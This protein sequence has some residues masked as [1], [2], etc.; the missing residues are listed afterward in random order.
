MKNYVVKP[1][2]AKTFGGPRAGG[3]SV[4]HVTLN[5]VQRRDF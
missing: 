1:E 2:R 3:K 4:L 5:M